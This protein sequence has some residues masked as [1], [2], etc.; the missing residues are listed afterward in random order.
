MREEKI[1]REICSEGKREI[2][3]AK[4]VCVNQFEKHPYFALKNPPAFKTFK[5]ERERKRERK[6]E[7]EK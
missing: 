2:Y 7:R 5:R 1:E 3:G 4:K 6:S